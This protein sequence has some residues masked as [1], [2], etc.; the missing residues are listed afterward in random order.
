MGE[1]LG[2]SR[3]TQLRTEMGDRDPD[4]DELEKLSALSGES[5]PYLRGQTEEATST[6]GATL[7]RARSMAGLRLPDM[8]RRIHES[9]WQV[10][11][12]EEDLEPIPSD[13]AV[14][15]AALLDLEVDALASHTALPAGTSHHA[16][17][18]I[19]L[20]EDYA[21]RI[22]LPKDGWRWLEVRDGDIPEA[23]SGS[24]V[25]WVKETLAAPE[26]GLWIIAPDGVP[27]LR[28]IEKGPAGWQATA[29]PNVTVHTLADPTAIIGRPL[30][31]GS[32]LTRRNHG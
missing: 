4:I 1:Y 29:G 17:G 6:P 32:P 11:Q 26:P 20:S 18:I 16:G 28:R 15:L 24:V 8:A 9:P 25:L 19:S 21:E 31:I 12:W 5:I 27:C 3:R 13:R 7:R 14:D 22:H 2:T 30:W 23:P 10:L